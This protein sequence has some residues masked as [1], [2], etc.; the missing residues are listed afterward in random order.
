MVADLTGGP[1][2]GLPVA[3]VAVS[4]LAHGARDDLAKLERCAA[5]RIFLRPVVPLDDLNIHA[6]GRILQRRSRPLGQLHRQVDRHA[7]AG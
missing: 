7:H 5:R 3:A 6:A 2:A 4:G 1:L